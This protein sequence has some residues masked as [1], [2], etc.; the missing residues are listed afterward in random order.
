MVYTLYIKCPSCE[1]GFIEFL[2]SE[3]LDCDLQCD[4]KSIPIEL[5][6][7]LRGSEESCNKC[8]SSYT[9]FIDSKNLKVPMV[10]R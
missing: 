6:I 1:G 7:S 10:L 5:A 9:I 4:I 8:N 3:E 2:N